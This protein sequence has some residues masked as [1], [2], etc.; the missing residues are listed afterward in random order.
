MVLGDFN[1]WNAEK[2]AKLE[3]QADGSFQTKIEL[4]PGTYQFRYLIDGKQW[5]NA[6][7]ADYYEVSPAFWVENS[8]V[9]VE[10]KDDLK[11]IEG[12]GPKIEAILLAAGIETFA[13]LASISSE[14]LTAILAQNVKRTQMYK[15]AIWIEQAKLKAN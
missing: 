7:N 13:Q 8:V 4:A 9:K 5:K 1:D 6:L 10:K 11:E 14:Q 2:A 12:I 3:V 15:P